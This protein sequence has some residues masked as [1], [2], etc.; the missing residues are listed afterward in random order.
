MSGPAVRTPDKGTPPP[1]RVPLRSRLLRWRPSVST[2]WGYVFIS[3]WLVGFA[4]LYL[5]PLLAITYFGFTKYAILDS[6]KWIGLANYEYMFTMDDQFWISLYNT[7]YYTAFRV[8]IHVVL[9]F[10]IALLVNRRLRGMNIIRTILYLPTVAPVVA[11]AAIWGWILHP[12]LGILHYVLDL[13]GIA[14]PAW[15]ASEVW[16]KP[17]IIVMSLWPF[18]AMMVIFLAGLQDIPEHL[19]EAAEIDGAGPLRRIFSITI[20]MMTPIFLYNII[21]DTINSF[22]VFAIAFVLTKGGPLESTLFYVLYVYK[23]AFEYFDMGYASALSVVLFIISFALT[24]LVLRT[25]RSWVRYDR[26]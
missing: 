17:S 3:P 21:L 4:F 9:A 13:V 8:P 6:P 15:L 11:T 19:Y 22:Q 26:I 20:P 23:N 1:V 18:G 5:L 2:V 24:L 16:S 7:L 10:V 25:S 14:S 12:R